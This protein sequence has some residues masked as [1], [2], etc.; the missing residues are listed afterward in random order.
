M[1]VRF[2]AVTLFRFVLILLTLQL[3]L[4][5]RLSAQMLQCLFEGMSMRNTFILY[6]ALTKVGLSALL[7]M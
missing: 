6:L 3:H 7:W 1:V 4:I 2:D 5:L